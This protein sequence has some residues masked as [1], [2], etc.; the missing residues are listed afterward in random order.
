LAVFITDR[1]VLQHSHF[2][3]D[4]LLAN[5]TACHPLTLARLHRLV[6]LGFQH[7]LQNFLYDRFQQIP[8]RN[9]L[10]L[11]QFQRTKRM[12]CYGTHGK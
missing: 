9:L 8:D 12:N 6:H 3:P 11:S 7:L 5:D 4:R 10:L 1:Y 2:C